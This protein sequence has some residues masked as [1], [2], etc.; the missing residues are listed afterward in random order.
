MKIPFVIGGAG[1]MVATVGILAAGG[2]DAWKLPSDQPRFRAAPGA[3]LATAHCLLCHSADYVSMQP[4]LDR[5]AW[6]ATVNKMREKYG[7]PLPTNQVARITDYL[8]AA[9]G[10]QSD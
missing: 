10:K 9:Y 4:P 5:A 2:A 1:L 3:E 7:A 8:A 6:L